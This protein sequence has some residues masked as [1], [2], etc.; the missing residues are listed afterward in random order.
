MD[1]ELASSEV[2]GEFCS[3]TDRFKPKTSYKIGIC[4]FSAKCAA[5]KR[6]TK[7]WMDL[8]QDNVSEWGNMSIHGVWVFFTEQAL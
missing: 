6:K 3:S 1:V 2:D 5:L 7:D 8:N 4:C